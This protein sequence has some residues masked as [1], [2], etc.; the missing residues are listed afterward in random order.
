LD[1]FDFMITFNPLFTELIPAIRRAG[2]PLA[3]IIDRLF[4]DPKRLRHARHPLKQ[5]D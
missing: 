3:V 4:N 1:F 5:S 2:H